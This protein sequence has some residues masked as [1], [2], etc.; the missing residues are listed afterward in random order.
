AVAPGVHAA[1]W[2]HGHR[3]VLDRVQGGEDRARPVGG[4][5]VDPNA[6]GAHRKELDGAYQAGE[7]GQG[8]LEI[9]QVSHQDSQAVR[10]VQGVLPVPQQKRI[11]GA[12]GTVGTRPPP[13]HRRPVPKGNLRR[14]PG[15]DEE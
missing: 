1:R 8:G 9:P 4:V 7:E 3:G 10:G 14:R 6:A 11:S 5:R 13:G 2:G 15:L 12:G